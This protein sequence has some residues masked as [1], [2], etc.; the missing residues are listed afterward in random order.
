MKAIDVYTKYRIPPWLQEHQLRVAGVGKL[1]SSI[2]PQANVRDVTLV[3]LFHDMGNIL[4]FDLAPDSPLASL[5]GGEIEYWQTVKDDYRA[6]YGNSEY[7]ATVAIA[8]D[9][10]LPNSTVRLIEGMSYSHTETILAEGP[11]ELQICAY[12]DMRIGPYGVL[13][14]RERIADLR[15][16]AS[17]RWKPE[18]AREQEAR[19]D[20][21]MARFF[22]IE[23]VIFRDAPLRP[24]DV[25]DRAIAPFISE[26]KKYEIS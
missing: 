6:A 5:Y 8:K 20:E 22:G 26:L 12:A 17:K 16:R 23:G 10:P 7:D 13:P 11:L 3:C 2:L 24:E 4:K 9:I 19:F 15:E 1:M 25:T 14:L 18:T 21:N